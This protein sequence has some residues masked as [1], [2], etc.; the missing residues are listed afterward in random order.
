[1]IDSIDRKITFGSMPRR[2]T[3][4][5]KPLLLRLRDFGMWKPQAM[6]TSLQPQRAFSFGTTTGPRDTTRLASLMSYE[7]RK[8]LI[9]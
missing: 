9:R 2:P 5:G 1:M 4:Q 7:S 8:S 6:N 3:L